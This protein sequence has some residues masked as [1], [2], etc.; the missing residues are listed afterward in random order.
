MAEAC[1]L[2]AAGQSRTRQGARSGRRISGCAPA[3]P[4]REKPS[5]PLA[6]LAHERMAWAGACARTYAHSL[7]QPLPAMPRLCSGRS[8]EARRRGSAT[9]EARRRCVWRGEA[10]DGARGRASTRHTAARPARDSAGRALRLALPAGPG[11]GLVKPSQERVGRRRLLQRSR[12]CVVTNVCTCACVP[13]V[14]A[15]R[16]YNKSLPQVPSD[17]AK[18]QPAK[19]PRPTEVSRGGCGGALAADS[20]VFYHQNPPARPPKLHRPPLPC[21]DAAT[22]VSAPRRGLVDRSD[23]ALDTP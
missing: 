18:P 7:R 20:A 1:A 15:A 19:P 6:A 13:R 11:V 9:A 5:A 12:A 3:A 4:A 16:S 23:H 8:E 10:V 17:A 22:S 2:T 21:R 14:N